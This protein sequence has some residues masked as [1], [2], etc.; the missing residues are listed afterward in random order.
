MRIKLDYCHLPLRVV[1]SKKLDGFHQSILHEVFSL[2]LK[3]CIKMPRKEHFMAS[4]FIVMFS[5]KMLTVPHFV[6]SL[7]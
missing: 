4:V 1:V 6:C 3:V 7:S 2:H 5:K